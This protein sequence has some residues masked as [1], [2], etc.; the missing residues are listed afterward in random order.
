MTFY[1]LFP[2]YAFLPNGFIHVKLQKI[3]LSDNL[4][5]SFVKLDLV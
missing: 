5:L 3:I 1:E 2:C 4:R